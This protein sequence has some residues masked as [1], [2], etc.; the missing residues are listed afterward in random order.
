MAD[1]DDLKARLEQLEKEAADMRQILDAGE[2]FRRDTEQEPFGL[3]RLR[4]VERRR[5]YPRN[6]ED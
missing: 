3:E 6:K 5:D 4:R 2:E 1:D